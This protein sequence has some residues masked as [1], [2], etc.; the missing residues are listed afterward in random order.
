MK[1]HNTIHYY[2]GRKKGKE[3][4]TVNSFDGI[5]KD[6]PPFMSSLVVKVGKRH[7]LRTFVEKNK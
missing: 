3:N 6:F 4:K 7:C 2:G 1:C 5:R